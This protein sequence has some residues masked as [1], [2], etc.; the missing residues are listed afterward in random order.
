MRIFVVA[1]LFLATAA[2]AD[3]APTTPVAAAAAA[4][5][6]LA[7]AGTFDCNKDPAVDITGAGGKFVL[8]GNCTS[9]SISGNKNEVVADSSAAVDIAGS[10]N[11]L[12]INRVDAVDI[13]G[14]KNTVTWM[15]T[16]DP[17]KTDAALTNTGKDNTV[18]KGDQAALD[19]AKNVATSKEAKKETKKAED[20]AKKALGGIKL[21]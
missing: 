17:K 8:T 7:K 21:P 3:G 4:K 1:S 6:A 13:K 12:V 10:E 15:A 5:K 20:A 11:K 19:A 2:L 9:V 18:K 16:V 14:G